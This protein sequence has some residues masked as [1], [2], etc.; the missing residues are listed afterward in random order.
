MNQLDQLM[1]PPTTMCRRFYCNFFKRF[2]HSADTGLTVVSGE[3]PRCLINSG[4]INWK[5]R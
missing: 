4:Y 1:G 5:A 3:G 2:A